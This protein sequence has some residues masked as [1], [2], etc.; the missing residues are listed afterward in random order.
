MC[1]RM[2]Q[3]HQTG[4][5]CRPAD[6]LN[7]CRACWLP[8]D[9]LCCF[10]QAEGKLK[11]KHNYMAFILLTL[12]REEAWRENG[13]RRTQRGIKG[14]SVS[15]RNVQLVGGGM[16]VVKISQNFGLQSCAI[17]WRYINWKNMIPYLTINFRS[18]Q[19]DFLLILYVAQSG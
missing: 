12:M 19:N 16:L 8:A 6:W 13:R 14:Y 3:C 5:M 15:P 17:V 10:L 1:V 7:G 18:L 4:V 9:G 11:S 2:Q